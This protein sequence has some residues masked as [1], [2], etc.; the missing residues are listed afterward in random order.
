MNLVG[1]DMYCSLLESAVAELKGEKSET[2]FDVNIDLKVSAYI[3]KSYIEDEILRMDMYKKIASITLE[4]KGG[5][6]V[7][8]EFV[9]KILGEDL[10]QSIIDDLILDKQ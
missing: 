1:Y 4:K 5:D 9:E 3:P 6:G 10:I 8:R 2:S 7:F